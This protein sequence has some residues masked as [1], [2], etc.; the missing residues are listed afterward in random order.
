MN[1]DKLADSSVSAQK[2]LDDAVNAAQIAESAVEASEFGT[3]QLVTGA[4]TPISNNVGTSASAACPAGTQVL[5]GGGSA[6]SFG[7][8]MVSSFQ[9]GNGWIVAYFNESGSAQTIT[10]IATCLS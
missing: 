5:S 7:V 8:K 9:S 3:T 10:A 4:A 2:I 6:S 1:A